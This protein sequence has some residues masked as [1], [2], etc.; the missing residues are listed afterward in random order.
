MNSIS[1][2]ELGAY[3]FPSSADLSILTKPVIIPDEGITLRNPLVIQ[4]LEGADSAPDG[5]PTEYTHRRYQRFFNT[6]AGLVWFESLAV[7]EDG[8]SHPSA[9]WITRKNLDT[10][11][12]LVF[13]LK[14]AHP[15]TV[16]VAQLTH[17]GRFS[18]PHGYPEPII[19]TR[20]PHQN[21]RQKVSSDH[22]LVTDEYLDRLTEHFVT[23][24]NLCKEAGFDGV[25]V[26]ACH[27][28]LFSELLSAFNRDGR[29]G[30]SFENRARMLLQTI[31]AIK[32]QQGNDLLVSGRI[33]HSDTAPYPF[34]FGMK[35]DGSMTPDY[36]EPIRLVK[37]MHTRG[38]NLVN[39]STSRV[40][41]NLEATSLTK[42]DL[43]SDAPESYF[44]RFYQG[45]KTLAHACPEVLFVG[46]G[47][48]QLK[49]QAPQIA[50][51]ALANGDVGLVGFG[52]MAN[53]CPDFI[54][55]LAAG[56]GEGAAARKV[57]T[58]C[59]NCYKL[60]RAGRPTGCPTRDTDVFL[61]LLLEVLK[62]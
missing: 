31:E 27:G 49:H 62:K 2:I 48:T 12:K 22:P 44:N 16:F 15:D 21:G 40:T 3:Q 57:C 56:N 55:D 26:K 45:T 34:G 32:T 46:S 33:C 51:A 20:N 8:R 13:Q 50:A 43:P 1:I 61:P 38:V 11:K 52:R 35:A 60:L 53:A 17:A 39:V 9:A 25:D 37:E 10:Y 28:Y 6:D 54:K 18:K 58:L 30:G 24:A 4:P 19:A 7:T 59:G 36:A 14:E 47:Y 29:Y 23:A 42:D 5:S 41:V